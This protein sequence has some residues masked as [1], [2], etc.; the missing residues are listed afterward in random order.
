MLSR[1]STNSECDL[2]LNFNSRRLSHTHTHSGIICICCI[3]HLHFDKLM[4]HCGCCVISALFS[5]NVN[6]FANSFATAMICAFAR[7]QLI[8]TRTD[9]LTYRETRT[10]THNELILIHHAR[11][12]TLVVVVVVCFFRYFS[13]LAHAQRESDKQVQRRWWRRRSSRWGRCEEEESQ[14]ESESGKEPHATTDTVGLVVNAA[15]PM[16]EPTLFPLCTHTHTHTTASFGGLSWTSSFS[17]L[18]YAYVCMFA[19]SSLLL[20][21]VFVFRL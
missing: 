4:P 6:R 11:F 21:L 18:A 14:C 2:N 16:L 12:S 7:L 15:M 19:T 9:V 3:W 17:V 10:R 13:L 5:C 8:E 1:S 20:C